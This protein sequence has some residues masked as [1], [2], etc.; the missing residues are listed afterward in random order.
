VCSPEW[1]AAQSRR[2]G[3]IDGRHHVIVNMDEFDQRQLRRWLEQRVSS[4]E[5]PTWPEVG[6][7]LARLG[8][9]EFEDYREL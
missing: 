7:R 5:S 8:Y 6:G 3:F 2:K 1:L 4:V 9:W